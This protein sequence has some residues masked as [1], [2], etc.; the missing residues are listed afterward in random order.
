MIGTM[1]RIGVFEFTDHIGDYL[2]KAVA[3][4]TIEVTKD[5]RA[6]ARL[7]PVP[8]PTDVLDEWVAQ[9]R[10]I[11]ATGDIREIL[12]QIQTEPVSDVSATDILLQAREEE[13][14]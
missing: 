4:E 11:P 9:G 13:R 2:D 1:E 7:V 5:G 14:H 6:V 12:D 10:A 8:G 3:G